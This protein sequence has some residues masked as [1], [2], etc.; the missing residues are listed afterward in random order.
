MSDNSVY[1]LAQAHLALGGCSHSSI[2]AHAV[3]PHLIV[4]D[5]TKAG[6]L[7]SGKK[8]AKRAL[9]LRKI[10]LYA[11]IAGTAHAVKGQPTSIE[12]AERLGNQICDFLVQLESIC[13][14]DAKHETV[15]RALVEGYAELVCNASAIVSE[16]AESG[17]SPSMR[18]SCFNFFVSEREEQRQHVPSLRAM[19]ELQ[20]PIAGE[21]DSTSAQQKNTEVHKKWSNSLIIDPDHRVRG[22]GVRALENMMHRRGDMVSWGLDSCYCVDMRIALAHLEGLAPYLVR[23]KVRNL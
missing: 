9:M 21:N 13:K 18:A 17:W 20:C 1:S 14:K 11:R 10:A 5:T 3:F 7:S 23:D 19:A 4:L 8:K 2:T 15:R 12:V 6:F 16:C 22:V